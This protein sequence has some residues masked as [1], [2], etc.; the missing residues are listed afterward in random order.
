VR[1]SLND[2]RAGKPSSVESDSIMNAL[3]VFD[4]EGEF[5]SRR[6]YIALNTF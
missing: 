6:I 2:F 3:N 1:R 5:V 4:R